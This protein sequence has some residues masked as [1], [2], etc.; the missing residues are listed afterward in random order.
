MVGGGGGGGGGWYKPIIRHNSNSTLGGV[1][2]TYSGDGVEMELRVELELGN[3]IKKKFN[4][5]YNTSM[6][7]FLYILSFTHCQIQKCR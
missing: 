7:E 2:L 4:L 1:E 6:E 3:L 5:M